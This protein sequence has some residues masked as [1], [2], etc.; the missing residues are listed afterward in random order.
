MSIFDDFTNQY[1]LSKTLR[2]ELRP[3]PETKRFLNLDSDNTQNIFPEDLYR[4]ENREIIKK[5]VDIIHSDFIRSALSEE[6]IANYNEQQ[7]KDT[8]KIDFDCL[9]RKYEDN[10]LKILRKNISK[11]FATIKED[12]FKNFVKVSGEKEVE[13]NLFSSKL[14]GTKKKAGILHNYFKKNL[15][16]DIEVPKLFFNKD[17]G[18]KTRKLKN[19]LSNFQGFSTY[20]SDFQE[21]RK[22]F[23]K[24]E[25]KAGQIITRIIDE[26][27]IRFCKNLKYF[28]GITVKYPELLNQFNKE[29]KEYLKEK[30][31]E[32]E[33]WFM[34]FK[35]N[36]YNWKDLFFS[37]ANCYKDCFLQQ[38]IN[39]YNYII[40][41][42][43]KD[44]NEFKQE[45]KSKNKIEATDDL[46]I[47]DKLQKQIHGAVEKQSDFIEV[48]E[49][50]IIDV[51]RKFIKHCDEKKE[52]S[53]KIINLFIDEKFSDLKI[54]YLS[55]RAI[56][57]ISDKYFKNWDFL[58]EVLLN[59]QNEDKSKCKQRKSLQDF[60]CLDD[61]KNA[62][63]ELDKLNL[64]E[65]FKSKY[66]DE[67]DLKD[68]N[69]KLKLRIEKGKTWDNLQ[70]IFKY[71]V[72]ELF[73]GYEIAKDKLKSVTEYKKMIKIK[74]Q[75]LKV[76]RTA[77]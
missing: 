2:F 49:Q 20:L 32:K 10:D 1:E 29:W 30:E 58:K 77:P 26:N 51:L 19:V 65:I 48:D 63:S 55:K 74:E 62:L 46:K 66:L 8:D 35:E 47:F 36:K 40:R 68:K 67:E 25:G 18:S 44:I 31:L 70:A 28:E 3:V 33:E 7:A 41:K 11:L 72:D 38:G 14:V 23:Y 52:M 59:K 17:E 5:Y 64:D 56:E 21:N 9:Y 12:K 39:Q 43:N 73:D 57:T 42:L 13:G 69:G 34:E 16:T 71:E 53:E 60:I 6:N 15:E 75:L 50:T 37:S 24:S 4:A 27:L 22:N 45:L 61:F 54:V 76:L